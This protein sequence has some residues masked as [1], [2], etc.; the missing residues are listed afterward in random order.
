MEY[1]YMANQYIASTVKKDS[2]TYHIVIRW[3]CFTVRHMY[4]IIYILLIS[5][6]D[7]DI[8]AIL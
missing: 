3:C 4:S 7:D 1:L 6:N 8:I 5:Y 2:S